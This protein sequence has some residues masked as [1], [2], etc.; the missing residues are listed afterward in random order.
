MKKT[1]WKST[2]GKCIDLILSNQKYSFKHTGVSETGL[3]DFHNL[4]YIAFKATYTRLPPQ[5]IH[6]RCYK[7]FELKSFQNELEFTLLSMSGI[8]LYGD[9]SK[10][11]TVFV[12]LLNKYAPVKCKMVRGNEKP[13]MNKN[14]KKE[15]M[16]RS[17]LKNAFNKCRSAK[18]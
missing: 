15:I 17:R 10:F 7:N 8:E 13:H 16:I 1:C 14:L 3:S 4:I 2:T 9:Y 6:Y 18:N 11:K 12:K 5:R